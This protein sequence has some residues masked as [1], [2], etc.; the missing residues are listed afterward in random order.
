MENGKILNKYG[1]DGF[2]KIEESEE[3]IRNIFKYAREQQYPLT[4]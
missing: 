1:Y 4:D 2:G 3:N